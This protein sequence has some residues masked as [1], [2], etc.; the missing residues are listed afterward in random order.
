MDLSSR[1]VALSVALP[2]GG[3]AGACQPASG[4]AGLGASGGC[5]GAEGG[6]TVGVILVYAR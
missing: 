5:V 4:F 6:A 3:V 2:S 1:A